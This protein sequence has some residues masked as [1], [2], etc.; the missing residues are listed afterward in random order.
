MPFMITV[1]L[2]MTGITATGNNAG[3]NLYNTV[4]YNLLVGGFLNIISKDAVVI[5]N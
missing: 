3:A 1:Y 2:T 4:S 5:V